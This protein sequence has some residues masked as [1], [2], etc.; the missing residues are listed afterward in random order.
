M[1]Y[2]AL[3]FAAGRGTRMAPLTDDRPK[4]L[5]EVAGRAL[6]DHALD[7]TDV[8]GIGPRVVNAHYRGEMLHAHLAGRDIA[9]SDEA[10]LLDTGGGLRHALPLLGPG[11]VLTLNTDAVWRG[12]NPVPR[13]CDAFGDGIEGLLLVLPKSRVHGHVG[14]GD[15]SMDPQGR[16]TRGRDLVYTGLQI[17]RTDRL[18]D[19]PKEVFSLNLVWDRMIAAGTL[20]GLVWDGAWCDVGRP[21][22]IPLAEALLDRAHV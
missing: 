1:R 20:H 9:I 13:I 22:T 16:L 2:P 5:V 3:H 11:P 12:S 10:T 7:L 8:P 4:P 21:D 15:F 17:L 6:L 19:I 18:A 14:A